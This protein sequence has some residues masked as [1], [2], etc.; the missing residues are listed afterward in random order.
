[1]IPCLLF[2]FKIPCRSVFLGSCPSCCSLTI[3]QVAY[4]HKHRGP[5]TLPPP[6][7]SFLPHFLSP[8]GTTSI[9]ISK[10]STLQKSY[11]YRTSWWASLSCSLSIFLLQCM[12]WRSKALREAHLFLNYWRNRILHAECHFQHCAVNVSC[13]FERRWVCLCCWDVSHLPEET[14]RWFEVFREMSLSL[15]CPHP[16]PYSHP[17]IFWPALK[18]NVSAWGGMAVSEVFCMVAS[19]CPFFPVLRGSLDRP[20]LAHWEM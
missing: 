12:K 14:W 4:L 1:M 16:N 20:F 8:M 15:L 2:Y 11:S 19:E 9:L 7:V 13:K 5:S 18:R 17:L 3:Q 10:L 6:S